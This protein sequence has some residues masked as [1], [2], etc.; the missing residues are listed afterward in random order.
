MRAATSL[1]LLLLPALAAPQAFGRF[2]YAPLHEFFGIQFSEEGLAV[3]GGGKLKFASQLASYKPVATSDTEQTVWLG[4]PEPG[5]PSKLRLSMLAPGISLFFEKGIVLKSTATS[6]PYLTWGDGS[7]SSGVPTPAT[8]WLALSY[9]DSQPAVLFGMPR[10]ASFRIEGQ[11]GDWTITA[12]DYYGWLRVGLPRGRV[13]EPTN[14]AAALG[15]LSQACEDV[16]GLYTTEVPQLL[17]FSAD[18]DADGNAVTGIW[19]F[20]RGNVLIPQAVTLSHLGGYPISVKTAKHRLK[21]D[22]GVGDGPH[23]VTDTNV[24]QVRFPLRRLPEGR[25]IALGEARPPV[26]T[27]S[28]LD[29]PGVVDLGLENL[30]AARD[31]LTRKT[32]EDAFSAFLSEAVY[33]EEPYSKQRLTF[34][35]AG[36]GIDV[37]AAQAL[38]AQTLSVA[39]RTSS[40]DNALL[41]SVGWR[42]D[43][44]TWLPWVANPDVKRRSAAL[45]AIA[46]AFCTEP[47]R[48]V[49]AAM[50]QAGLAGERGL[51]NWH[52]REDPD[53]PANP[54]LE[55]ELPIRAALFR[56][57]GPVEPA[58]PFVETLLSPYR[59]FSEESLHLTAIDGGYELSWPVLEPKAGVLNLATVL[60]VEIDPVSNLPRFLLERVLGLAEVRYTPEAQG[61]CLAR[62]VLREGAPKPP[63]LSPVKPY[64]E[65]RR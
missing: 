1:S 57:S 54:L 5:K 24:L 46:G 30:L 20:D 60:P 49:E 48:R 36:T 12:P 9:R 10:G 41:T 25:A 40:D 13:S 17:S 27:V 43:W 35:G 63:V 39:T 15:R 31:L 61:Y 29:I 21:Q 7:V 2:G 8:R 11:P 38:L 45:A 65:V 59:V 19:T 34:D 33:V 51:E 3:D 32:A 28:S 62:L 56:L 6:A 53:R 55:V 42:R 44:G 52:R 16:A 47:N 64:S 58:D 22:V 37:T 23:D 50:F 4:D 14:T 18:A 26:G